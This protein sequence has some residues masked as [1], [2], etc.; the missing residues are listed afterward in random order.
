MNIQYLHKEKL[1]DCLPVLNLYVT[2]VSAVL[3]SCQVRLN[4]RVQQWRL[5]T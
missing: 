2:R 3:I 1:F 4:G 5:V